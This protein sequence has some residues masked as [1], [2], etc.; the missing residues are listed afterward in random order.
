TTEFDLP[1]VTASD[2]VEFVTT[3]VDSLIRLAERARPDLSAARAQVA[4]AA[5]ETRSAKAANRP[6]LAFSST[7][8]YTGSSVAGSSGRNS[9]L[10]LGLQLPVFTGFTNEYRAAEAGDELHAAEA[11]A[12]QMRQQIVLQV[13]TAYSGLQTATRRVGT[14]AELLRAAQQSEEVA[15]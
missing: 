2:S 6:A 14:A 7:A 13:L 9:P 8:G 5:A 12:E 10:N 4:A 1:D 3:S 15:L 11:R